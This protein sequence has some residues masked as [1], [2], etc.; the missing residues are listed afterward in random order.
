[1]IRNALFRLP[2]K[3]DYR[4][5][6]WVT[7]TDPE[8]AQVGLTEAAA[9]AADG[10]VRVL[11]WRFAENDRARTDRDT[12]GLVK[13]VTR[14]NGRSL[15]ASILGAGAGDLILPALATA[16]AQDRRFANLMIPTRRA[17]QASAQPAVL[18]SRFLP[19]PAGSSG[20]FGALRLSERERAAAVSVTRLRP[21]DLFRDGRVLIFVPS[22]ARFR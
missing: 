18:C 22:V 9:R 16:K 15:G 20:C 17:K 3:V 10:A 11:R 7:Y 8:L 5:L 19:A 2:A 12:G 14:R 21:H 6:P 4:S 1:V 13:I